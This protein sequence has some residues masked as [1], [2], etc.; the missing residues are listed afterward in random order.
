MRHQ[1]GVHR[2][3]AEIVARPRTAPWRVD[4]DDVVGSWPADAELVDWFRQ[5][6][7]S[8]I[9]ALTQADPELEC[10]TF[11]PA[12]SPL[13]MWA[14]RQA[15]ETAVHR[16]DAELAAGAPLSPLAAP[17]AADG[18]DE[19]LT[20]F[21]TRPG[22]RLRADPPR[23]LGVRCT[24]RPCRRCR[25]PGQ[26]PGGGGVPGLVEPAADRIPGGRRGPAG[27]RI[28]P[29]QSTHPLA[30]TCACLTGPRAMCCPSRVHRRQRRKSV[31]VRRGPATV[32]G[33][34][35][36]CLTAAVAAAGRLRK[37]HTREPGT[38]AVDPSL[39][40]AVTPRKAVHD[41]AVA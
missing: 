6:H 31:R 15:H 20:C 13:A 19:L 16:A 40:G 41:D 12:P 7:A 32:T 3:A 8:L 11:L 30:L 25:L 18:I 34:A 29:Q 2:W 26:R 1:G 17:F 10:W 24:C 36:L 5:G 4:L 39:R 21:I 14:R 22:G 9:T 38:P 35:S 37:R 23:V 33:G 28:V 27:S